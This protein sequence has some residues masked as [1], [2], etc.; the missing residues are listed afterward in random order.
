MVRRNVVPALGLLLAFLL[1]SKCQA[2]GWSR[3]RDELVREADSLRVQTRADSAARAQRIQHVTDSTNQ[4]IAEAQEAAQGALRAADMLRA[5][6]ARLLAA[7]RQ[8]APAPADSVP[9]SPIDSA[10]TLCEEETMVLRAAIEHNR[11]ALATSQFQV[12]ELRGAYSLER[13]AASDLR[14]EL[15]S[16]NRL[17]RQADPPCRFLL[18][19]CPSRTVMAIGGAAIGAAI[20]YEVTRR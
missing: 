1:I 18:W 14:V 3:E 10:L 9:V 11:D 7:A 15:A 2:D 19:G 20:T 6:R 16:V 4:V 8:Q 12:A 13:Q 5:E 17:L